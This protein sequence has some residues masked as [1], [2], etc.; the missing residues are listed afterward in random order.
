MMTRGDLDI[1]TAAERGR[2]RERRMEF[3]IEEA[4]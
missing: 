1:T 4:C 2:G 3:F